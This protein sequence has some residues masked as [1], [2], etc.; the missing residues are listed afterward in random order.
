MK[1]VPYYPLYAA[2]IIASRPYRLMSLAERGLWISIYMECW[3]NGGVPSDFSE[4]AKILGFTEG[5]MQAFFT[6]YQ[7]AFF[8]EVNG[9]FISTELEEYREGFELKRE[10][11]RAG[12]E[13]GAQ[14]KKEKREEIR[15]PKGQPEGAPKGSLSHINL[16]SIKSS[17][18]NSNQLV[19]KD[20]SKQSTSE[21]VSDYEDA[22]D[23]STDY[24]RASKG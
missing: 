12:G 14:I 16:A 20:V 4:M 21:W 13:K 19:K 24:L 1:T 10:K 23:I 6:K 8:I 11:Q 9:Q 2:N 3:V 18:I 15:L 7:T 22:P 17:S 5:E